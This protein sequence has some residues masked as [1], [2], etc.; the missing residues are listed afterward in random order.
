MGSSNSGEWTERNNIALPPG[1]TQA[2]PA[3][4]SARVSSS[5]H[6]ASPATTLVTD[7]K[8][9][10]TPSVSLIASFDAADTPAAVLPMR[11]NQHPLQSLVLLQSGST[12]PI[13]AL[14]EPANVFT[15]TTTAD[16]IGSSIPAGSLREAIT[17]A[18]LDTGP[19][20]IV[21][22]FPNTDPNR[23]PTTGVFLI[24]PLSENSTLGDLFAL[25]PIDA[26]VTI[27]GYTQPGA[28]PNTLR[29]GTMRRF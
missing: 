29:N 7:S 24:Q 21:F 13:V 16:G 4:V 2:A 15:V 1:F 10:A 11:L 9:A 5:A 27:D 8:F 20:C 22:D 26:T 17:E 18:N 6:D 3:L 23:D 19:S 25:P 12:E 14:T 28:S